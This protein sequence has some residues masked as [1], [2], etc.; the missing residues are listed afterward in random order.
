LLFMFISLNYWFV[1]TSPGNI[2]ASP[3]LH[4]SS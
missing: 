4:G 3:N 2:S 1:L